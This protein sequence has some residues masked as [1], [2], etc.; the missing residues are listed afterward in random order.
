[1]YSWELDEDD[2]CTFDEEKAGA[3]KCIQIKKN[4]CTVEYRR[5]LLQSDP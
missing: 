5:P 4:V 3:G 2:E 1:M